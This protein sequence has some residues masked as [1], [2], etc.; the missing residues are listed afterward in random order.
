[1]KQI[2]KQ[3]KKGSTKSKPAP[4]DKRSPSGGTEHKN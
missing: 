1:M 3:T 4:L 2:H